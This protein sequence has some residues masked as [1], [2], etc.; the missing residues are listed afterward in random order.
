[1]TT[2]AAVDVAVVTRCKYQLTGHRLQIRAR[3]P[4]VAV[5]QPDI[6]TLGEFELRAFGSIT[7]P[8]S[9]KAAS[10]VPQR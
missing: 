7:A 4:S 1:M 8:A 2:S 5:L 10:Q 3:F 9:F 6:V